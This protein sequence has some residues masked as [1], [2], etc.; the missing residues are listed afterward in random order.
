MRDNKRTRSAGN[1]VAAG[2]YRDAEDYKRTKSTESLYF[3]DNNNG[4]D[5]YIARPARRKT[6]GNRRRSAKEAALFRRIKA[7]LCMILF[8]F[9]VVICIKVVRDLGG[10]NA[11]AKEKVPDGPAAAEKSDVKVT[12]VQ[13]EAAVTDTADEEKDNG[14]VKETKA[15]ENKNKHKIEVID[16]ITYVD[17]ILIANKTYSLPKDYNPGLDPTAEAA[18][19]KMRLDAENDGI[20]L[21]ICSGFRSYETQTDLYNGYV[22]YYGERTTDTFSAKPGHSEHQSGLAMDINDASDSFEGT[23]EAKWLAK[24]CTKYGFIIRYKKGKEDI[25]GFKYEPWHIRYLGVDLAKKV[26]KTGLCLEEYLEITSEYADEKDN[27]KNND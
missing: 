22:D 24:N 17:G 27:K 16:G 9:A 6:S 12:G 23:P 21:F 7:V 13:S 4:D 8:A 2:N 14:S 25:T 15:K 5:V 11:I 20:Y 19:E 10:G 1:Y 3:G 18:F 26:E